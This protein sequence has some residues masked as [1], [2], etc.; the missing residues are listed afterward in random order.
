MTASASRNSW[1]GFSSRRN[2]ASL[3]GLFSATGLAECHAGEVLA[4][5][6]NFNKTKRMTV[7]SV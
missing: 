3:I 4:V 6:S 1:V 5:E 2:A 7:E